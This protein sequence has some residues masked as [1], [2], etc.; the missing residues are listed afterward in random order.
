M[1]YTNIESTIINNGNIGGYFKLEKWVRQGCPLSA[2]LF[3]LAIE[4]LAYKIRYDKNIKGIKIDNKM[5]KISLL[6]DNVTLI[7][8]DLKS[9]EYALKL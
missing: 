7:L 6:T 2:Y 4:V 9:I 1:M 5:I 8:Q 3:I